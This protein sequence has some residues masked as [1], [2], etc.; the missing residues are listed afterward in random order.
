MRTAKRVLGIV[1]CALGILM[2]GFVGY[3]VP[4]GMFARDLWAAVL[5]LSGGI[6]M[7]AWG[8]QTLFNL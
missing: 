3:Q 4:G 7:L 8:A 1:A 2:L 5:M 6:L